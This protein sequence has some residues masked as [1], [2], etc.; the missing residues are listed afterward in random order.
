MY[1]TEHREGDAKHAAALSSARATKKNMSWG[2]GTV[3]SV[4]FYVFREAN[5]NI[6]GGHR[7]KYK[8]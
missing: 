5:W 8:F 1:L 2:A 6:T 7:A 4:L 3:F